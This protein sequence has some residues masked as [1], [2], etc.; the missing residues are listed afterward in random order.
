MFADTSRGRSWPGAFAVV[1]ECV[2]GQA[3][4]GQNHCSGFSIPTIGI[5]AGAECDG[6]ILVINDLLG[7]TTKR[8]PRF[9]L[10]ACADLKTTINADAATRYRDEVRSGKF[11]GAEQTFDS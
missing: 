11:P 2:P 8:V 4:G 1:L 5:G 6:Q 3:A 9:A 10:K 7:M